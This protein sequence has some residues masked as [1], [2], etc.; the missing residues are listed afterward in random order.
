MVSSAVKRLLNQWDVIKLPFQLLNRGTNYQPVVG[1]DAI[2]Y[3]NIVDNFRIDD[4]N[5]NNLHFTQD[6][7]DNYYELKDDLA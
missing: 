5:E 2:N 1:L 6:T 3:P 7:S 4:N